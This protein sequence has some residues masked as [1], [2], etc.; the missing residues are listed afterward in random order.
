[1]GR[2]A[3]SLELSRASPGLFILCTLSSYTTGGTIHIYINI[4]AV[5]LDMT[6]FFRLSL[7]VRGPRLA[8]VAW[9]AA[10]LA[11]LVQVKFLWVRMKMR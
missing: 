10:L 8:I 7:S 3:F 11:N 5:Q 4:D 9:L 6:S 2:Q 1:M